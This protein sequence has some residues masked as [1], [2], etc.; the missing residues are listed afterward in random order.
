M[1]AVVVTVAVTVAVT[2][3]A[4]AVTM[5]ALTVAAAAVP[6][7]QRYPVPSLTASPTFNYLKAKAFL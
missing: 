5:V 1:V 7:N 3:A 6:A 2:M 4:V